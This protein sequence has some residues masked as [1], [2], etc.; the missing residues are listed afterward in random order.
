MLGHDNEPIHRLPVPDWL[1]GL[2]V[3]HRPL[4]VLM[5]LSCEQGIPRLHWAQKF[6]GNE[7]SVL[8]PLFDQYPDY[9]PFEVMLASF[10]GST[11][12][13]AIERARKQLYAAMDAGEGEL[14]LRPM[15]NVLSR[16]RIKLCEAGIEIATLLFLGYLLK[17]VQHMTPPAPG[18]EGGHAYAVG[19]CRSPA[20]EKPGQEQAR[21]NR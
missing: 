5:H 2:L 7:L 19:D 4:G 8:L 11:S 1:P 9:C 20:A 3:L 6:T 12:D 10:L 15:R 16:V 21:K 14:L 18:T 17:P 13:K